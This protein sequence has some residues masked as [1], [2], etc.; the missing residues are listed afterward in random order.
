VSFTLLLLPATSNIVGR[1][2]AFPKR[3]SCPSLEKDGILLNAHH[4]V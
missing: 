2:M 4:V 3:V 1:V